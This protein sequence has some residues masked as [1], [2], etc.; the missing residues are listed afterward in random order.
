MWGNLGMGFACSHGPDTP[1]VRASVRQGPALSAASS[2]VTRGAVR[3]STEATSVRYP[4]YERVECRRPA[5]GTRDSPPQMHRGLL[6]GYDGSTRGA[7]AGGCRKHTAMPFIPRCSP[8]AWGTRAGSSS[9][10]PAR[11]PSSASKAFAQYPGRPTIRA[12]ISSG[13]GSVLSVNAGHVRRV[14]GPEPMPVLLS[15]ARHSWVKRPGMTPGGTYIG[16]LQREREG[17]LR[18]SWSFAVSGG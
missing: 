9:L 18:W 12:A 6:R 16:C 1:T 4:P 10:S 3:I 7:G 11:W 2:W 15:P 8:L 5:W 17:G 13:V 14:L